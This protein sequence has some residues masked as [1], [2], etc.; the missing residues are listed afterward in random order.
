MK[1]RILIADDSITVRMDLGEALELA[2]FDTVLCADIHSAKEALAH[3]RVA[4]IVLDILLSDG[5]GQDFFEALRQSPATAQ[6][7]VLLLSTH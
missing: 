7:P 5:R 2:G 3:E 6:V 4:L 1:P